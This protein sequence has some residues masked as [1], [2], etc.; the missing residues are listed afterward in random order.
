MKKKTLN[1]IKKHFRITFSVKEKIPNLR[2]Q[3]WR[4]GINISL[5]IE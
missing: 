5:F 3:I 4:I 1:W 2:I